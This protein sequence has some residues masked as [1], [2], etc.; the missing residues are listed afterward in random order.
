[1]CVGSAAA[2]QPTHLQDGAVTVRNGA[3]QATLTFHSYVVSLFNVCMHVCAIDF[4]GSYRVPGQ[5]RL[6]RP[7]W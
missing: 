6:S 1:M 3:G 2:V 5:P 4:R 7:D